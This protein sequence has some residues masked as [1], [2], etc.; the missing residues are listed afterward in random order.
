M[1]HRIVLSLI[2]LGCAATAPAEASPFVFDNGK[3]DGRLASASRPATPAKFEIESADDFILS[4]RTLINSASF[5]GLLPSGT[6]LGDVSQLNVEIYR[7][8]PKDSTNPPSGRVPTRTNS[9]SDVK[10]DER[11]SIASTLNFVSSLLSSSF[12][13]VNSVLPG[14]IHPSPNQT[15]GGN[16]AMTGEE[17]RFDVTFATP[18]DLPADHY[19][20]VPQVAITGAGDFL[21]LS[22]ARPIVAPGTPFTPDLQAWARDQ[23][24][25]P[26]WLRVGTDIVGGSPAPTFNLAFSLQ[27]QSVSPASVPEPASLALVSLA[28]AGLAVF[29]RKRPAPISAK[30]S[31]HR[32]RTP[33]LRKELPCGSSPEVAI[34]HHIVLQSGPMKSSAIG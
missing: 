22:S 10:F 7:I 32:H 15:T 5:T 29:G 24:L 16:G 4:S 23:S 2:C 8:F 12:S 18:F 13:A 30:D 9:P 1:K 33:D 34:G 14:G 19:F 31:Q 20:F 26:D 28:I 21:W 25:D 17:V 3:V 11:G 6:P 27:G